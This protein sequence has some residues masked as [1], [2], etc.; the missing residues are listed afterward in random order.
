MPRFKRKDVWAAAL[1]AAFWVTCTDSPSPPGREGAQAPRRGTHGR[2]AHTHVAP[3]G[4]LIGSVGNYHLELTFDS[5]NG[6]LTLFTLD[7]DLASYPV[8]TKTLRAPV[9]LEG[10]EDFIEVEMIALPQTGDPEGMTSQ[11]FGTSA[12][13]IGAHEFE[14]IMRVPFEDLLYRAAFQ[15]VPGLAAEIYVCPMTHDDNPAY[16]D[17]GTCPVC[18]M[19]L[20]QSDTAHGDHS[21]KHGGQ[22]FMASDGWHHLE[23]TLTEPDEF[24]LYLYNNF[25]APLSAT[26]CANGSTIEWVSIDADGKEVSERIAQ[27]L[28]VSSDAEYLSAPVPTALTRPLEATVRLKFD[29]RERRDL[30]T[31]M[32]H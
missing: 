16:Y 26:R 18:G 29:G 5:N 22:F 24:R 28:D 1:L 2:T 31:F 6:A 11:F 25:S 10:A 9:R 21:P 3:H 20:V 27:T 19:A 32:F 13:L 14:I 17:P 12:E 15:I 7:V 4:G 8:A 30:F 23:G